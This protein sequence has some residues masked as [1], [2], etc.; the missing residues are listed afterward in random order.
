MDLKQG[1]SHNGCWLWSC[2]LA[3]CCS[4]WGGPYSTCSLDVT[5]IGFPRCAYFGQQF[6]TDNVRAA[7]IGVRRIRW[8]IAMGA[9]RSKDLDAE[10]LFRAREVRRSVLCRGEVQFVLC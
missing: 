1:R 4:A 6:R 2:R 7:L 8:A 3:R 10:F 5:C 9:A